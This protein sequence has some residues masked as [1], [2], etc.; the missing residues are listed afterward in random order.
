[1]RVRQNED[2]RDRTGSVSGAETEKKTFNI[3]LCPSHV[4]KKW[5]REIAETLPDTVGVIVR[6]IVELDSLYAQYRQGD[7][8]ICAVISKEKSPRRLYAPP[9]GSA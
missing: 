7:K 2:R 6:S 3:V 8:S 9:G 5:V 4:A 1:M